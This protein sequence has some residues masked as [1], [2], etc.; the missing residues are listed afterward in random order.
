M[1]VSELEGAQLDFWVARADPQSKGLRME[2]RGDHW[3][4]IGEIDGKDE[5]I[6]AGA[7]PGF[8]AAKKV[9]MLYGR[10]LMA[11]YRPSSDWAQGGPLIEREEG[12]ITRDDGGNRWYQA[13]MG[14]GSSRRLETGPAHLVAAMRAFVASRF[15]VEVE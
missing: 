6:I 10:D 3:V 9:R 8:H 1:K 7:S 15:G 5:V 14:I 4:G 13:E 11:V 2:W 12:V